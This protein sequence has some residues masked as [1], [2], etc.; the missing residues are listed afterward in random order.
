MKNAFSNIVRII[1]IKV[2][3]VV[4]VVVVVVV[5]VGPSSSVINCHSFK[6]FIQRFYFFIEKLQ[7]YW[8]FRQATNVGN[9]AIALVARF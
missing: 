6:K 3:V 4:V 5:T 7:I 8:D 9:E 2:A 1:I